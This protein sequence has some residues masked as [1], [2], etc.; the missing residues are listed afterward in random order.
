L[1]AGQ[2]YALSPDGSRFAILR[3]GAIEVY[4]LPPTSEAAPTTGTTTG[5]H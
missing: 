1:S 2:N 3:D 4:D 5:K